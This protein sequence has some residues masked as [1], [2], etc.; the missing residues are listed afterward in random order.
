MAIH[1]TCSACHKNVRASDECGGLNGPCP[2]CKA[3]ISIPRTTEGT[4]GNRSDGNGHKG[5]GRNHAQN[6]PVA[7][8]VDSN[9]HI[10]PA[11][12]RSGSAAV[13]AGP[14]GQD[15][16]GPAPSVPA[17]YLTFNCPGCERRL[18]FP[19]TQANQPAVCPRCQ[20]RVMVPD[21]DGGPSFIV[22][23]LAEAHKGLPVPGVAAE[24]GVRFFR[25]RRTARRLR[26]VVRRLPWWQTAL[27]LLGCAAALAFSGYIIVSEFG[28]EWEARDRARQQLLVPPDADSKRSSNGGSQDT[29]TARSFADD[30]RPLPPVVERAPAAGASAEQPKGVSESILIGARNVQDEASQLFDPTRLFKLDKNAPP[31]KAVDEE[32]PAAAPVAPA[33]SASPPPRPS[34]VPDEPADPVLNLLEKDGARKEEE[35]QKSEAPTGPEAVPEIVGPA[36]VKPP[37]NAA[38]ID[39]PTVCADCQGVTFVPLP[40]YKWYVWDYK[41]PAPD[42]LAAVPYVPC[43][44]CQRQADPRAL[45]AAEAERVK[46][47]AACINE[48]TRKLNARMECGETRYVSVVAQVSGASLKNVL[49]QMDK[50]TQHLQST[51]RSALLAQTRPDTHQVIVAWD[52]ADYDRLIDQL[53]AEQPEQDWALVRRATGSMARQRCFFNAQRG[54]G[55]PVENMALFQFA[56][57]LILEGTEGRSPDW[58]TEGFA[59]YCENAVLKKNL[60][61]TFRYAVNQVRIGTN[62]NAEV[63]RGARQDQLPSWDRLLKLD[64]IGMKPLDYLTCY[65]VVRFLAS[66]PARF[67]TLLVDIRAGVDSRRALEHAYGRPLDDLRKMWLQWAQRQR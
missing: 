38:P 48:W 50:L 41:D 21:R 47:A 1:F 42:P 63:A 39:P 65:S 44:K 17:Q 3:T 19:S 52:R 28:R 10:Q 11:Q 23:A 27:I 66:D 56:H 43:P 37:A 60:C 22:G 24:R 51:F 26:V 14:S 61:Y 29:R 55:T 40:S 32:E 54:L 35:K 36:P 20:T 4:T 12:P 15:A 30:A 46:T 6:A 9:A 59:S 58:L 2:V 64:L 57:M 53:A 62:W 25:L 67:N 7:I 16:R 5:N 45:V 31:A 8:Q 33:Q 34:A 49:Q 18:G 13:S